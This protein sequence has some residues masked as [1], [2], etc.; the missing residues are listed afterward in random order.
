MSHDP[1]PNWVE[2][3]TRVLGAL[4]FNRV[5]VRWKLQG[6][7]NRQR[8][9]ARRRDQS[10]AH[11]TYQHRV[12]RHC[13]ALN[14]RADQVCARCG[15]P[16][17]ARVVE[18]AG[19]L[20]LHAP[21]AVS[22][23]SLLGLIMV[24]VH[25]RLLIAHGGVMSLPIGALIEH[26][27]SLSFDV[28]DDWWRPVTSVL[29]HAGLWHLLF[30]L[31]ALASI[32][33]TMEDLYGRGVTLVVFLATGTFAA[34]GSQLLHA[35]PGMVG[36]GASGAIMG[37][38]GATAAAGHR[39]GTAA[40]RAHR[41]DMIKWAFYVFLFGYFLG[42][43]NHAHGIGLVAG[44]AFGLV[45]P[46]AAMTRASARR[47]QRVLAAVGGAVLLAATVAIMVPL[48]RDAALLVGPPAGGVA[49]DLGEW[50]TDD[51]GDRDDLGT[52]LWLCSDRITADDYAAFGGEAGVREI[53]DDLRAFRDLCA[54]SGAEPGIA[55]S[56]AE[57]RRL[58]GRWPP[59]RD[60]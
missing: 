23:A 19:R 29:L 40:G 24:A 5:R 4:G 54:R 39:A 55:A 3:V 42:A 16:L 22:I 59:P 37:L 52:Q 46:P 47:L 1:I 58:D 21:R 33:S 41:D 13:K 15:Q 26:G 18:L 27:G 48:Q 57:L 7:V 30:N 9:A 34:V 10:V 25:A 56:C 6:W 17:G 12:C 50:P 45:V 14:D 53:C 44:V 51:P 11:V 60:R 8:A 36:I 32:S 38:V 31:F 20:G 35:D 43:D 2:T 28:T 49:D